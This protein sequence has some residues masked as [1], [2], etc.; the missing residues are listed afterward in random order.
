LTAPGDDDVIPTPDWL[1]LRGGEVKFGKDGRSASVYFAG[2]LQYVLVA[3]PARGKHACRISET[4]NGRRLD[5]GT[6]YDTIDAALQGG[7]N[8]LRTKLGW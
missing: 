7:L 1:A 2:Q 8:E 3:V 4:V 5:S 6:V